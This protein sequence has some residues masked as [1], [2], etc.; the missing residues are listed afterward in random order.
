M[1]ARI[2]D[3]LNP[4][5]FNLSFALL[6]ALRDT[7][8]KTFTVDVETGRMQYIKSKGTLHVRSNDDNDLKVVN[9]KADTLQFPYNFSRVNSKNN[10]DTDFGVIVEYS[11]KAIKSLNGS[12]EL[13]AKDLY[14]LI[15]NV[16][17]LP[18]CPPARDH[19]I[20]KDQKEYR[21][22]FL[23]YL[24]SINNKDE[25]SLFR[26]SISVD[27]KALEISSGNST[28]TIVDRIKETSRF[29]SF[30]VM[31]ASVDIIL[32]SPEPLTLSNYFATSEN[33]RPTKLN[34]AISNLSAHVWYSIK[35]FTK[36]SVSQEVSRRRQLRFLVV[37]IESFRKLELLSIL[38]EREQGTTIKS[39]VVKEIMKKSEGRLNEKEITL[40]VQR[41]IRIERLLKSINYQ[42]CVIDAFDN[43]TPCF[44]TSIINGCQ[45]FEIWLEIVLNNTIITYDEAD[46]RYKQNKRS[47]M[48][49]RI[50]RIREAFE[51]AGEDMV[52]VDEKDFELE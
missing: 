38:K 26:G 48:I 21:K 33:E 17:K 3:R 52:E 40:Y 7:E 44:F 4:N 35:S 28:S 5:T 12:A 29:G 9:K 6:D 2:S 43:L 45:N 37:M 19:L 50:E 47:A 23:K 16:E 11:D 8:I 27:L 46:K 10:K 25:F 49:S 13:I 31:Q 14:R 20:F 42:W 34:S 30:S 36:D 22:E 18:D 15:Q 41:A 39:Q 32:D 1:A 51:A 24:G